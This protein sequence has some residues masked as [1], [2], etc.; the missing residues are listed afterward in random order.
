MSCRGASGVRDT[1]PTPSYGV[2]HHPGGS[3]SP[4]PAGRYP[5]HDEDPAHAELLLEQFGRDGHR[6]EE[7]EAPGDRGQG[8]RRGTPGS[9]LLTPHLAP[10]AWEGV[11]PA[12]CPP[13]ASHS[14]GRGLLCVVSRGADDGE[15]VLRGQRGTR[16]ACAHACTRAAAAHTQVSVQGSDTHMS[17]HKGCH[18]R[19]SVRTYHHVHLRKRAQGQGAHASVREG[20]HAHP[21]ERARKR[22]HA[23]LPVDLH[24]H[25]RARGHCMLARVHEGHHAR[26][27]ERAR[28]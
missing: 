23:S 5:V 14:H 24:T 3:P 10:Q 12:P 28:Y 8:Q 21:G 17:T 4:S 9:P 13:V 7:T 25:A 16:V 19:A 11:L 26:P 1:P 27:S 15:A 22:T 18:A 2:P 6:V 20:C